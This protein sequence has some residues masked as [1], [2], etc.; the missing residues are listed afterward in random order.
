[1]ELPLKDAAKAHQ[2]S[3][4]GRSRGKIVLIVE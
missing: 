4:T 3:E 1:M 2:Q